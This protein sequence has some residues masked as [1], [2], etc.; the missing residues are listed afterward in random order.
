MKPSAIKECSARSDFHPHRWQ[1]RGSS[2]CGMQPQPPGVLQAAARPGPQ[3]WAAHPAYARYWRHYHQAMAW[4]RSHHSA[5]RKATECYLGGPWFLPPAALPWSCPA[6]AA[7]PSPPARGRPVGS[8]APRRRPT[9][10]RRPRRRPRPVRE[11]ADSESDSE[12]AWGVECDVS[13]MEITEELRQYF[14]ETERHREERR[15]QQQLDAQRLNDYVNAD[16]G[17]NRG[18]WR[19]VMPPSERPGERRKAEMKRLYGAN[20]AKIQAMETAVQ[21]SFDK[22]CDRKQPKYWPVIPLKF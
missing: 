9:Q 5:Y 6:N 1:R 14:A 10:A 2:G 21:L 19:S 11:E 7:R 22:H 4:M 3:P 18:A 8:P 15:R 16:H 13:N 17:L 12:S 20:A